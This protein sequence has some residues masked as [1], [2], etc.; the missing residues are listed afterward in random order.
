MRYNSNPMA[1]ILVV[2]DESITRASL[3]GVL[4]NEGYDVDEAGDGAQALNILEHRQFDLVITDLVMPQLNG[5]KLIEHI[6]SI[7]SQVP[8]ILVSAYLP[9]SVGKPLLREPAEFIAKPIEPDV[10][11]PMVKDL[12]G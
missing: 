8:I 2:E 7:P 10:L 12:L 6:R 4:R 3:A 11:L 9:S 5:F 1:R